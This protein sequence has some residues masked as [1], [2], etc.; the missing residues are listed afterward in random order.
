[1]FRSGLVMESGV[2]HDCAGV[3]WGLCAAAMV[4]CGACLLRLGVQ[5]LP[6]L[7]LQFVEQTDFPGRFWIS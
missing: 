1:M 5:L 4:L 3:P 6:C 7:F 2:D